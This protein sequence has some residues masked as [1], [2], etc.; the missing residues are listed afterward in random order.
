MT[1]GGKNSAIV[2]GSNSTGTAGSGDNNKVTVT[3]DFDTASAVNGYNN[4]VSVQGDNNTVY[5]GDGNGNTATHCAR[6]WASSSAS[7]SVGS[8]NKC[9]NTCAR[10]RYRCMSFSN[11]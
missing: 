4:T 11:V 10:F 1:C 9:R 2:K 3:G 6:S 7:T 8:P 5:A